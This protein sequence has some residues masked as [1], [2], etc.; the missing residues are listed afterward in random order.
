LHE[1]EAIV[2]EPCAFEVIDQT[3]ELLIRA[4]R[5]VHDNRAELSP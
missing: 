3:T 1:K 2:F 4:I 5:K